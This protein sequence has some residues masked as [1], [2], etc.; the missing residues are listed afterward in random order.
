[1]RYIHAEFMTHRVFSRNASSSRAIPAKK[2]ISQIR[3]EPVFFAH[4][5]LNEPGMQASDQV[6][7]DVLDKFRKEWQELANLTADYVERWTNEY[8]IHKQV[9]NRVL[10]AF[11]NINVVVTSS[12]WDNFFEL[13]NHPDAQPEI[14][15]LAETM[16]RAMSASNPRIV[17]PKD[18]NDARAWHLPYVTMQERQAHPVHE[19][20]AMS[21][22][23]CARV[24]YL[25]HDGQNP[26]LAK[27]LELYRRLVESRPLHASP[28]EHQA[29]ATAFN[30][31]SQNLTGGWMQHRTL[32]ETAGSIDE[33]HRRMGVL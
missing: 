5:G 10:E 28:L 21:A 32:L 2:L 12:Q 26:L 13:R 9:A 8:N 3:E 17:D 1:P 7:A 22:A 27:D 6:T 33:M 4:V 14:K 20:I 24:S 31:P 19:L 29:I 15:D 25:T 16:L 23:R 18:L 30:Y 11:T